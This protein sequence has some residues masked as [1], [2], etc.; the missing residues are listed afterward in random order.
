MTII[1]QINY[2]A[3]RLQTYKEKFETLENNLEFPDLNA[4][5]YLT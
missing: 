5:N 3:E 4:M 1:N 2:L